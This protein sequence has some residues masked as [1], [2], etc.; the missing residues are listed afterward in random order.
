MSPSNFTMVGADGDG[1]RSSTS[2]MTTMSVRMYLTIKKMQGAEDAA[3]QVTSRS[4]AVIRPPDK[5]AQCE[6]L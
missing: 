5:C 2:M 1:G 4:Q 6:K 3:N